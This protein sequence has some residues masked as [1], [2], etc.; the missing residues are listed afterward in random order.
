MTPIPESPAYRRW[1]LSILVLVNTFNF[2]DRQI[3]GVLAPA[4]KAELHLSDTQLGLLGGL[5][6]AL[7]Y[8]ALGIPI[9]WLA[10]RKSRVWIMTVALTLWS[11]FSAVCGLTHTFAQLFL[12]RLGVGVGEA[13]GVA[14]SYS[15]ISDYFPQRERARALAIYSFGIPFGSAAGILFGG[16]VASAVNWRWAFLAVGLAGLVIAPIFRLTLKEPPRGRYD[17]ASAAPQL[18]LV[19]SLGRLARTPSFWGLSFGAACSSIVGYGLIFWLPSFFMRSYH[20]TLAQMAIFL[21]AVLLFG[22][23]PTPG[24]SA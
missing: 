20:L 24:I 12:A 4:I 7:F 19:A 14:P 22:A 11:G 9:A 15:L 18:G 16:L 3:V 5:A 6:F 21:G 23:W 2:I 8:T 1:V 13:G 10:D 17:K